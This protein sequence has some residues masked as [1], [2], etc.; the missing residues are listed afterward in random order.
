M[1]LWRGLSGD[2]FVK[3]EHTLGSIIVPHQAVCELKCYC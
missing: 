1:F 2:K 3:V